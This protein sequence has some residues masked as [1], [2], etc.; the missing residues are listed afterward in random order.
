MHS[1]TD[2]HEIEA[3]R[4]TEPGGQ[5]SARAK[6]DPRTSTRKKS[7]LFGLGQSTSELIRPETNCPLERPGPADDQGVALR[8][9]RDLQRVGFGCDLRA[10][11]DFAA[12]LWTS[13]TG[14]VLVARLRSSDI[15]AERGI[16]VDDDHYSQ[17]L[18]LGLVLAGRATLEQRGHRSTAVAGEAFALCLDSPFRSTLA[19]CETPATDVL[20]LY[21]PVDSLTAWGLNAAAAGGRSWPLSRAAVSAL[22]VARDIACGATIPGS[23]RIV[24]R[25]DEIL[26]RAAVVALLERD[27][28]DAT[29]ELTAE[30]VLRRRAADFIDRNFADPAVNPDA[31][32]V[33][34]HVSR[35]TLFRAFELQGMSVGRLIRTRRLAAAASAL[36]DDTRGLRDIADSCGFRTVD[37]LSRAFR[38][39][40]GVTP[41][42][43]RTARRRDA[44]AGW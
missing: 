10:R 36:S 20:Y 3:G 32:A 44:M 29:K 14:S 42:A 37:Q 9:S 35:R 18:Q 34:L 39:K 12:T 19:R 1:E 4:P 8:G 7:A 2:A 41:A 6:V 33:R 25:I 15:T 13:S 26:F 22:M 11:E 16:G 30:D 38:A 17:Y 5:R 21:L 24:A 43:Y 23:L 27:L 31:V 28:A 40:Y